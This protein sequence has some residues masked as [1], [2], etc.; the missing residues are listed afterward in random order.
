VA[1]L[2]ILTKYAAQVA[3]TEENRSRPIPAAQTVFFAEVRKA[4]RNPGPPA[5]LADAGLVFPAVHLAI[6]RAHFAGTQQFL[7]TRDSFCELP[8]FV[9]FQVSGNKITPRPQETTATVQ[10]LQKRPARLGVR[11]KFWSQFQVPLSK[12]KAH[13]LAKTTVSTRYDRDFHKQ[14]ILFKVFSHNKKC[15]PAIRP[16]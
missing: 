12:T 15:V 6:T 8:H 16:C 2:E 11:F 5:G 10:R 9:S 13:A 4:A 7:R 1:D 14:K 3:A